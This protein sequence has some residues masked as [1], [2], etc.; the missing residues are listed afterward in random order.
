MNLFVLFLLSILQ[1]NTLT[2]TSPAFD[3]DGELPGKYS[4]DGDGINPPLNIEGIP[5]GTKSLV[6]IVEDPDVSL[7]TFSQWIVWNIP[8]QESIAENSIPGVEGNNSLGKN[9]YM[10]PCPPGGSHRYFFKV[11]ALDALLDLNNNANRKTLE[12]AMENHVLAEGEI[13]GRYRK[14]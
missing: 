1:T 4:C 11:Y 12:K 8:P 13:M 3:N 9:S 7:T 14:K 10:G 6:L 2:V 5:N